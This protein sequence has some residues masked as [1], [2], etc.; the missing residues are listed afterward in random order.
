MSVLADMREQ[1]VD[2]LIQ[3]GIKAVE[4]VPDN[5]APPLALVVPAD[6]QI[7]MS[8]EAS[9]F[10]YPYQYHLSVV[11]LAGKG[12]NKS[13]QNKIDSMVES[14]LEALEDWDINEVSAPMEM[15]VKGTPFAGVV[16]SLKQDTNLKEVI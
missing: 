5:V 3:A 8:E 16:I 2:A 13:A 11:L 4:Y 1:A 10:A 15:L 9:S 7:T 12:T 14:A 6:P